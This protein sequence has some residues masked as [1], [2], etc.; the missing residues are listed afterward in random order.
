MVLMQMTKETYLQ[1]IEGTE[2]V[3][4]TSCAG[5]HVRDRMVIDVDDCGHETLTRV[6]DLPLLRDRKRD[7]DRR[8]NL[9][10]ENT[11]RPIFTQR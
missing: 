8:S 11:Y 4:I 7:A 9:S 10:G 5:L 2:G 3:V 1:G 6:S